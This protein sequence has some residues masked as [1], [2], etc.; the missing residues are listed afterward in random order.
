MVNMMKK[1]QIYLLK[2]KKF[3]FK[4]ELIFFS[5]LLMLS[6]Q[7]NAKDLLDVASGLYHTLFLFD[8]GSILSTGD[9]TYGQLGN[10]KKTQ[11]G[12]DST[13]EIVDSKLKFISV[14][15]GYQHSLGITN[16]GILLGWGN[17]ENSQLGK[18]I[19]YIYHR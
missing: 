5:L 14:A 15:A 18:L 2:M 10:G 1:I 8:D 7:G 13:I 11:E 19:E 17:N 4:K 3:S 16:E 6:M 12:S 9:N